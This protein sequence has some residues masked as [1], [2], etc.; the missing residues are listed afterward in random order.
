[1]NRSASSL[2]ALVAALFASGSIGATFT[3]HC[4]ATTE[5]T[6]GCIIRLTGQIVP[7][8]AG[9]LAAALR[10]TPP[11]PGFYRT[12]VLNSAGGDVA[13]A[14][15]IADLVRRTVLETSNYRWGPF[16]D[17]MP[18]SVDRA[19]LDASN[20][21]M[22]ENFHQC[23]SACFVVWAAGSKRMQLSS[24]PT[25]EARG[26]KHGLGLHRPYFLAAEYQNAD[27]AT[28][29]KRQQDVTEA[30]RQHLR[31]EAIPD[32]L[33]EEMMRRSSREVLWLDAQ[34]DEPGLEISENAPWFEELL[35]AR[36]S[37]DPARH[38]EMVRLS[39][40]YIAEPA[41]KPP[42][43]DRQQAEFVAWIQGINHCL[44]QQVVI[45]AQN[46]FRR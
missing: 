18:K 33:I 15:K 4:D 17:A 22:R 43:F 35:I 13:E 1:M 38:R 25:Q 46:A 42:N 34:S 31:R 9:R 3:T 37:Y 24:S 41:R 2:L 12:L 10:A 11:P 45:P 7:G 21:A 19:A 40:N 16:A 28:I 29:A 5:K 14:I 6:A 27:P 36:C 32:R 39:I 8:D 30:L 20:R 26:G 44:L 23:A